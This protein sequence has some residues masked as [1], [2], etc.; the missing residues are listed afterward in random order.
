MTLRRSQQQLYKPYVAPL[1]ETQKKA[2]RKALMQ[3]EPHFHGAFVKDTSFILKVRLA[4]PRRLVRP[5]THRHA[6]YVGV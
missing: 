5:C 1:N 4:P 2:R 3:K 6:C